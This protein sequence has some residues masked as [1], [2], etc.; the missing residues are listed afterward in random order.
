MYRVK[1][2][3]GLAVVLAAGVAGCG[4][5]DAPELA[6]AG[7]KVTYNG[8]PLEGANVV[9]TP[10]AGGPAAYGVTGAD[11]EFTLTTRGEPGAMVGSG[12]VVISAYQQL[13]EPKEEHELTAADLEKMSQS[14]I[15]EKYGRPETSGLTATVEADQENRFTFELAD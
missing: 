9:Y 11:G 14:R 3:I 13:D 12:K 6:P 7:G 8:E 10:D 4:R 2:V 15:P 1:F 5:S